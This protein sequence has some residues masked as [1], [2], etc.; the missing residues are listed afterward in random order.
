MRQ[1]MEKLT[2]DEQYEEIIL[3]SYFRDSKTVTHNLE[4]FRNHKTNTILVVGNAGSGK[5]TY[6]NLLKRDFNFKII[7][8]DDIANNDPRQVEKGVQIIFK[9]YSQPTIIEGVL[10]AAIYNEYPRLRKQILSYPLVIMG[11]SV[12][13]STYRSIKRDGLKS[14]NITFN[15]KLEKIIQQMRDDIKKEK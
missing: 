2:F 5:T 1:N 12:I 4:N 13:K 8:L 7:N 15:K 14:N 9:Q 10:I 11:T 6:A 3:E